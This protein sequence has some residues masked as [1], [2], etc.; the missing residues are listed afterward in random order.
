MV[1]NGREA[2]GRLDTE[3][4]GGV[5][6]KHCKNEEQPWRALP[7]SVSFQGLESS[8]L[9]SPDTFPQFRVTGFETQRGRRYAGFQ[10][11]SHQQH[12]HH[13]CKVLASVSGTASRTTNLRR[14]AIILI[15]HTTTIRCLPSSLSIT[16]CINQPAN[17]PS[18][19]S[20][21]SRSPLTRAVAAS[22][23]RPAASPC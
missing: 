3:R 21:V 13:V 10:R 20:H 7:F 11:T 5:W 2:Q 4:H 16:P 23:R 15:A 9:R 1:L 22:R 8:S 6:P 18:L 19:K 17:H 14:G 12:S